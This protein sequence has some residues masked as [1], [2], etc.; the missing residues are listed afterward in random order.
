MAEQLNIGPPV[1]FVYS[2]N[3]PLNNISNQNLICGGQGCHNNSIV[4]K[5]YIASTHENM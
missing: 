2:T 3:L 5:L 4:T 1:Y